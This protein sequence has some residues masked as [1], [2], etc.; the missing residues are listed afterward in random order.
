MQNWIIMDLLLYMHIPSELSNK[1]S[2]S[3]LQ[4]MDEVLAWKMIVSK[5]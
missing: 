3:P 1:K 4:N 2:K 5:S